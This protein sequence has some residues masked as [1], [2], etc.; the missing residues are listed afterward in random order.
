MS[1]IN[2]KRAFVYDMYPFK[3]WHRRVDKMS[4]AQILAIFLREQNK[5]K[6]ESSDEEKSDDGIPF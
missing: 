5:A 2:K 4:D 6:E 3:G 1:D